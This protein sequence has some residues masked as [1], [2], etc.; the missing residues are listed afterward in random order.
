ML[1]KI[2][3][4]QIINPD[5]ISLIS[6]HPTN[7]DKATIY[8]LNGNIR[9][10]ASLSAVS[11]ILATTES[12]TDFIDES[13]AVIEKP[14]ITFK[15]LL[16]NH[17]H[18]SSV[19]LSI[20]DIQIAFHDHDIA[21]LEASLNELILANTVRMFQPQGTGKPLYYHASSTLFSGG[22]SGW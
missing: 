4:E 20:K 22:E 16:A 1:I 15:G 2:N 11:Y 9:I 14:S 5:H 19:G 6:P 7:P 12:S 10:E 3:D 13:A 17:L 21:F 18:N 8:F